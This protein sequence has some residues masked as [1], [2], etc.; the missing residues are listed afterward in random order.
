MKFY[1]K[2]IAGKKSSV[3][4][5]DMILLPRGR[6]DFWWA[7]AQPFASFQERLVGYMSCQIWRAVSKQATVDIA[8]LENVFKCCNPERTDTCREDEGESH[9]RIVLA[10]LHPCSPLD[11]ALM[12]YLSL[13]FGCLEFDS[14][15]EL[16]D[17]AY[18]GSKDANAEDELPLPS[19]LQNLRDRYQSSSIKLVPIALSYDSSRSGRSCDKECGTNLDS[20]LL[21]TLTAGVPVTDTGRIRKSDGEGKA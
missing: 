21:E 20:P 2:M 11:K 18:P 13:Y 19:N 4:D 6:W 3:Q 14:S 5:Q 10:P 1:L 12:R 15:D 9:P 17:A 7:L 16:W 8:S